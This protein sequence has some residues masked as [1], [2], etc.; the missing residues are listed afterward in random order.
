MELK[1]KTMF[2]KG[3]TILLFHSNAIDPSISYF[4]IFV[5]DLLNF[6]FWS[7]DPSKK[8]VVRYKGKEYTGYWSLCAAMNRALDVS[9]S[10]SREWKACVCS[11]LWCCYKL[12]E[13]FI[14]HLFLVRFD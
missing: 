8:F 1:T 13:L 5:C 14:F 7:E 10:I 2:I 6:S 9:T 3:A 4:R 12:C 11:K